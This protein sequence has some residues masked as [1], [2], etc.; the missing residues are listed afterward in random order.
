MGSGASTASNGATP[1]H[2]DLARLDAHFLGRQRLFEIHGL[3]SAVGE[4]LNGRLGE[5]MKIDQRT[6]RLAVRLLPGDPVEQ[7]KLLRHTSLRPSSLQVL[8]DSD[9]CCSI[10]LEDAE[11]DGVLVRAC[12]CRGSSGATHLS[13]CLRAFA[14]ARRTAPTTFPTCPTCKEPYHPK[15]AVTLLLALM[16]PSQQ[17]GTSAA[18]GA[19]GT[20]PTP[21]SLPSSSTSRSS[22][23]DAAAAAPLEFGALVRIA[24][25]ATATH[26]N[27]LRGLAIERSAPGSD[28]WLVQLED[29]SLKSVREAHLIRQSVHSDGSVRD[30]ADG[31]GGIEAAMMAAQ[32][33]GSRS[34]H[35]RS[36]TAA[37]RIAPEHLAARLLGLAYHAAGQQALAVR[38]LR[39]CVR[40][41]EETYGT[42]EH[43]A[44]AVALASLGMVLL[45]SEGQDNAPVSEAIRCL[46]RSLALEEA[47]EAT[48]NA[49][50][51]A[52][53]SASSSAMSSAAA[54]ASMDEVIDEAPRQQVPT[55]VPHHVSTRLALAKA[56]RL[57]GDPAAGR[58]LL[59]RCL[60][61]LGVVLG[62]D[63]E[64]TASTCTDRSPSTAST[65]ASSSSSSTTCAA[66]PH[67]SSPAPPAPSTTPS[68]TPVPKPRDVSSLPRP[69][70]DMLTVVLEEYAH[71]E[72]ALAAEAASAAREQADTALE[73]LLAQMARGECDG[74]DHLRIPELEMERAQRKGARQ[75]AAHLSRCLEHRER[76]C[77]LR[78]E[79]L[80]P[81]LRRLGAQWLHA[82]ELPRAAAALERAVDISLHVLGAAPGHL[83]PGGASADGNSVLVCV[84]SQLRDVY[85][86]QGET[87]KAEDTQQRIARLC[88]GSASQP[89][90][91]SHR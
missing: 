74:A 59:D 27:G 73:G 4:E 90:S 33:R 91:Q 5:V 71:A 32:A 11:A 35:W 70:T 55:G 25:L 10:C 62:E 66:S 53:S 43:P 61:V 86:A 1:T 63:V 31:D 21:S 60:E 19:S 51:N 30:G 24:G 82:R 40:V 79:M 56:Y 64:V 18:Q 13:C 57:R 52:S 23:A 12:A 75:A 89:R 6:G 15:V 29:G 39:E 46:E 41:A 88:A 85:V 37:A 36:P 3:A 34:P 42:P 83:P 72:L 44:V 69:M 76:V 54:R 26:L 78:H 81:V 14:A 16:G 28:R 48:S 50:S 87:A 49:T 58:D 22:A 7:W 45:D 17:P 38:D 77:G 8:G 65:S 68:T 2:E 47:S 84:L 80:I 20:A 67:S 9:T